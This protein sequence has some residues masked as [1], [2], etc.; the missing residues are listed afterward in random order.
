MFRR[1]S[2]RVTL[3]DRRPS[4][5]RRHATVAA[6]SPS[7]A[8]RVREISD[9]RRRDTRKRQS[10]DHRR[11]RSS[12]CID[13]SLRLPSVVG[14]VSSVQPDRAGCRDRAAALR[15]EGRR[16]RSAHRPRRTQPFGALWGELDRDL[17]G[18]CGRVDAPAGRDHGCAAG[19][20]AGRRQPDGE[21]PRRRRREP[22]RELMRAEKSADLK[23]PQRPGDARREGAERRVDGART[24]RR[25]R[26]RWW[27]R[28]WGVAVAGRRRPP[29]CPGCRT[30]GAGP[31]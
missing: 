2:H 10:R 28:R 31:G 27:R 23:P 19:G 11:R 15:R 22:D 13:S 7:A 25:W 5:P 21:R 12:T 8:L 6:S 24:A 4:A 17:G 29:D 16:E 30:A 20:R 9:R 14:P 18:A 1:V 26:W 3:S